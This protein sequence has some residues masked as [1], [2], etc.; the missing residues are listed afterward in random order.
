MKSAEDLRADSQIQRQIG[1]DFPIV[2]REDT[3][4]ISAVLMGKDAAAAKAELWR[5][6]QE[7]LKIRRRRRTERAIRGSIGKK[8]FAVEYLGKELVKIHARKL[9]AEAEK[10]RAFHPAQGVH[11]VGVV[12]RL[13]LI[14]EWRRADFKPGAGKDKFVNGLR[15]GSGWPKDAD[16]PSGHRVHVVQLIVDVHKAKPEFVHQC[17]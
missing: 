12:L 13:V 1:P 2:L 3:V 9:A 14:P 16:V 17:G 7:V 10:V 11:E 15:H 6:Q 5:A 8:E 4:I